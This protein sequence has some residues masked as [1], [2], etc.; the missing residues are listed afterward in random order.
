MI[1]K[2]RDSKQGWVFY[3][4]LDRV[5][6]THSVKYSKTTEELTETKGDY[7]A[8]EVHPDGSTLVLSHLTEILIKEDTV[9]KPDRTGYESTEC[10]GLFA[11]KDEIG[12]FII[13]NTE[14]Y[15]LSDDGKTIER[16]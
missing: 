11:I 2:I 1:L 9:Y 4:N 14:A 10:S 6:I 16:L 13:F 5:K 15:L 8:E 12:L 3:D 7:F